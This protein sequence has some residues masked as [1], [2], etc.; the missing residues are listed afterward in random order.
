MILQSHLGN[1][2]NMIDSLVDHVE[3]WSLT[4]IKVVTPDKT[5]GKDTNGTQVSSAREKRL[6]AQRE[7]KRAFLASSSHTSLM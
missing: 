4:R 7:I 6:Q 5:E 3:N 2:A 1:P